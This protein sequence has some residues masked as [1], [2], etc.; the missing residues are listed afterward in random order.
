MT[1][2][3]TQSQSHK[4]QNNAR[5]GGSRGNTRPLEAN[6]IAEVV[7]AAQRNPGVG[8]IL[9]KMVRNKGVKVIVP[10]TAQGSQMLEVVSELDRLM[11]RAENRLSREMSLENL[12]KKM[13]FETKIIGLMQPMADLTAEV[14]VAFDYDNNPIVRHPLTKGALVRIKASKSQQAAQD[15]TPANEAVAAAA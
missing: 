6:E 3:T 15:A 4:T 1:E 14:A 5:N 9:L 8:R 2:A 12:E 10:E 7:A 11:S 13:S